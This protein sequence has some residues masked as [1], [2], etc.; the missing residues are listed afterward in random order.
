MLSVRMSSMNSVSSELYLSYYSG[1]SKAGTDRD[2]H[3]NSLEAGIRI[4]PYLP[5]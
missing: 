3:V 1:F 4:M 2:L 5:W